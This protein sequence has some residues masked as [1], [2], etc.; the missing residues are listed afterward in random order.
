MPSYTHSQEGGGR[1][2]IFKDMEA[3]DKIVISLADTGVGMEEE[4]L[5]RL[6]DALKGH[7]TARVGIG[8]GNIYQRIKSMYEDGDLRIYSKAGKGTVVQIIPA[9]RPGR[10]LSEDMKG[11]TDVAFN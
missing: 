8:L 11:G 9:C 1:E 6:M 7:R 2:D 5:K 10:G 3:E 4:A